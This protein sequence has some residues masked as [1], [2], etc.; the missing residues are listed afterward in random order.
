MLG[1][2]LGEWNSRCE[3]AERCPVVNCG[4]ARGVVPASLAAARAIVLCTP[5]AA[6]GLL[7]RQALSAVDA[8]EARPAKRAR[9]DARA[10]GALGALVV[11]FA[12]RGRPSF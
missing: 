2:A 5:E 4:D 10:R 3:R 9:V 6:L 11:T 12:R 7:D 1:A 8:R